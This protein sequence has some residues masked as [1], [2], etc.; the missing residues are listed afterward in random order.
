VRDVVQRD[1][2]RHGRKGISKTSF[3]LK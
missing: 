1:V 3:T 2:D